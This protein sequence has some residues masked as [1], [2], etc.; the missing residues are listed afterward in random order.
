MSDEKRHRIHPTV[1]QRARELRQPQTQAE[2]ILWRQLRDRRLKG[3]KFRRQH[4]IGR[5][6]VDFCYPKHKLVVEIDGDTHATQTEYDAARAEW[7]EMQGYR[8]IRFT[9][10]EVY[11]QLPAV[12][13]AILAA[14]QEETANALESD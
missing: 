1:R 2:A 12:L 6:I 14:C 13:E 11:R 8:V 5:F 9:N 4:P 7:L 3:L 10:Q